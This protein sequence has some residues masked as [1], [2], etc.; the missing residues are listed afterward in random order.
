[1][2]EKSLARDSMIGT[3][4]GARTSLDI[5]S[6]NRS[7]TVRCDHNRKRLIRVILLIGVLTF[8]P[9]CGGPSAT[10]DVDFQN[11]FKSLVITYDRLDK[12]SDATSFEAAKPELDKLH[13][14]TQGLWQKVKTIPDN[15]YKKL[16]E[17]HSGLVQEAKEKSLKL[18]DREFGERPL[19]NGAMQY[20]IGE[21]V[22]KKW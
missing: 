8:L 21:E 14:V 11:L 13:K 2:L 22:Q 3:S 9:G 4:V 1:M 12:V 19:P 7:A 18:I 16:L 20:L 10:E 6:L 15:T 5:K 17:R